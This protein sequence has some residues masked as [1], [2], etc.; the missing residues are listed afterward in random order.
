MFKLTR[1][2]LK[3]SKNTFARYYSKEHEW[4]EKLPNS[5]EYHLGITDYAQSKLGEL[6]YIQFP[7]VDDEFEKNDEMGEIESPKAVAQMY[8]PLKLTILENNESLEDDY[9]IVN[10]KADESWFYKVRVH[11]VKELDDMI[12]EEEYKKFCDEQD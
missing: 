4:L 5:D 10:Q 11:D 3:Q 1:T 8:A 9:S 2:L 7:E 6:V 12:G